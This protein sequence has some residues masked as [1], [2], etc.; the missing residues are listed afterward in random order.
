VEVVNESIYDHPKYYDL[1]FGNDCAAELRF[2][3]EVIEKHLDR[4]AQRLFEPACGTG[5]L[6]Y[7]LAKRGFEVE[8]I[9]LNPKAVAF[10]NRRF[11]RHGRLPT[12]WV[13]DMSDF[14][15]KRK[16]DL[17]FNTINS[18]RHLSSSK[19]A[20]NHL[21]CMAEGTHPGGIYL[22][23]LHI[24]PTTG[25]ACQEESWSARRG[26][27]SVLTRMWTVERNLK[28][29]FERFGMTFD[30]YTPTRQFRIEDEL[31]MRSYTQKQFRELVAAAQSWE[32]M[33]TYDFTYD[34]NDPIVVDSATEDVVYVLRKK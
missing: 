30:V 9:D 13:A 22:V 20:L 12:A 15:P 25:E 28:R 23:G 3:C 5:R 32:I 7:G 1:I 16:W 33:E 18:F 24:V 4:S 26:H 29:R 21:H 2:I 10:S 27:L 8:G 19:A 17:A 34:I 31:N 6:L 11:E 14:R